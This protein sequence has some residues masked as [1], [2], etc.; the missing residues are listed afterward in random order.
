MVVVRELDDKQAFEIALIENVQREDL[1]PIE[2]ADAL[3][4]LLEEHQHTQESLA[5]V[6]GKDRT[7]VTNALRLLKLPEGVRKLVIQGELT[8]GH[9]RAILGAPDEKVMLRIAE[10]SVRKKLS[11]RQTEAEV[12]DARNAFKGKPSKSASTRDLELRLTRKLGS[13]CEVKDHEGKGQVVIHYGNL[14]E[15]DRLLERLL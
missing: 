9:A 6:V 8:E 15:L 14:D 12:R 11:V 4:V 13:R 10:L 2:F 7:T 5:Q 3:R 1:N